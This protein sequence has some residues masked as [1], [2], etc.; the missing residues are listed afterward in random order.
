MGESFIHMNVYLRV[1]FVDPG[2][3]TLLTN[4]LRPVALYDNINPVPKKNMTSFQI[5]K[6]DVKQTQ[7]KTHF[8]IHLLARTVQ[9]HVL[10][11]S[12]CFESCRKCYSKG[13]D[14]GFHLSR[15]F[16][17]WNIDI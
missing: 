1:T 16:S 4:I 12:T 9:H 13:I 14:K 10:K 6:N 11:I 3:I 8:N 5:N 7:I 17:V 15:V 2:T